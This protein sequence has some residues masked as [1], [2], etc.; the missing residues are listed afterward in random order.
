MIQSPPTVVEWFQV[1]GVGDDEGGG[2]D[3][4]EEVEILGGDGSEGE[5][6]FAEGESVGDGSESFHDMC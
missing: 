1:V 4:A 3:G 5:S 2:Q 6:A